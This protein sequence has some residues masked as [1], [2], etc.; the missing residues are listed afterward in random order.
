M[1]EDPRYVWL[2][3]KALDALEAEGSY[4]FAEPG[5]EEPLNLTGISPTQGSCLIYGD[6]GLPNQIGP[7]AP[8]KIVFRD[9]WDNH[10]TYLLF[11]LRFSGWHRYKATNTVTSMDQGGPLISEETTGKTFE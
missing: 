3:G 7:L 6:S 10:S 4:L 9:G 2:S 1:T 8:D 11:N 5:L